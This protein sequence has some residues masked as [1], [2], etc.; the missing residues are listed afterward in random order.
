MDAKR[1]AMASRS[2]C[3]EQHKGKIQ[4]FRPVMDKN[5]FFSGHFGLSGMRK[6]KK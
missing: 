3:K 5:V 2:V 6:K 1:S 4:N